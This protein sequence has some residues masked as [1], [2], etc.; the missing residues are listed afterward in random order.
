MSKINTAF[1]GFGYW[2]KNILRNLLDMDNVEVV[3][4]CDN[5][6]SNLKKAT[7]LITKNSQYN[8]K[9]ISTTNYDHIVA[10]KDIE[11]VVI[12]TPPQTHFKLA[13]EALKAGKHVF[14]EKPMTTNYQDA[15]D[16]YNQGILSQKQI[17]VGHTFIYHPVINDLKRLIDAGELGEIYH[18]DL[19]MTN[20]GKHQKD[21]VLW[22]LGPHG[23]SIILYLLNNP[24]IARLEINGISAIKKDLLD[25][26]YLT[27]YFKYSGFA[28]ILLSWMSPN[29][30]RQLTIVGSKKMAVFDDMS[31]LEKLRLYDKGITEN[32]DFS[33]WGDAIIGYR[34]GAIISPVTSSGEPLKIELQHFVDCVINN[35]KPITDGSHGAD[36]VRIIGVAVKKLENYNANK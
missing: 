9:L 10:E 4:V 17:M 26:A 30:T 35:K 13:M 20:L 14:I 7:E 22:D 32:K 28:N 12:A 21:N 16:L 18:I 5:N 19:Q 29:K 6:E 27:I 24:E 3:A 15:I 33:S 25:I 31:S 36:V 23:I 34:N 1:L 11:A 2:G 8:P